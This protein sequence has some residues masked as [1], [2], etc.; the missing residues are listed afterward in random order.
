MRMPPVALAFISLSAIQSAR[1]QAQTYGGF[2]CTIGCSGHAAGYKWAADHGVESEDDC[3]Q[4]N[5]QS[6]HEDCI[7]YTEDNTRPNP[8][9]DEDNQ[10]IS[11]GRPN[12]P[13]SDDED[14]DDK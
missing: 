11:T 3:P 2:D 6:F 13:D 12:D 7:A 4:G 9:A 14:E 5:S 1:A 8:D 10:M